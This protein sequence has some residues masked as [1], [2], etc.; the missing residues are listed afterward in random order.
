M[1][2]ARTAK[3]RSAPTVSLTRD[4]GADPANSKGYEA[5]Q[6]AAPHEELLDI[7][8]IRRA[9]YIIAATLSPELER[10]VI[11]R[12]KNGDGEA[13][14][15]NENQ[16]A[17][18]AVRGALSIP[19]ENPRAA[20]VP[21]AADHL[22]R[23]AQ[24]IERSASDPSKPRQTIDASQEITCANDI[25]TN[26]RESGSMKSRERHA[27]SGCGLSPSRTLWSAT[28]AAINTARTSES[29]SEFSPKSL[30]PKNASARSRRPAPSSSIST[31][32]AIGR[33]AEPTLVSRH[34]MF[35]ESS[36][37]AGSWG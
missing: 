30:P 8:R 34:E 36:T 5:L 12:L 3:K 23:T 33:R 35:E 9:I 2:R 10:I 32:S 17:L 19:T 4:N 14:S 20:G 1:L 18:R 21:D 13:F 31:A 25:W 29:E 6:V 37:S 28:A 27:M 15:K 11:A 7:A 24:A 26:S 22:I 16:R